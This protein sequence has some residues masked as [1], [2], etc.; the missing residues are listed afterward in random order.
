MR[1]SLQKRK[2]EQRRGALSWEKKKGAK[3]RTKKGHKVKAA[4]EK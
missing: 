4:G 3:Y 1:A 2:K